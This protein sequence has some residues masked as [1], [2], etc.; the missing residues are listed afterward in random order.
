MARAMEPRAGR[1][2]GKTAY[3]AAIGIAIATALFLAWGNLALGVIGDEGNNANLMYGGV[4]AVG[5]IG[6]V[7][8]RFQPEGMA[9]ALIATAI[10]QVLVAVIALSAGWGSAPD[11]VM[12]TLFF[13]GL[14]LVAAWLFGRAARGRTAPVTA[15]TR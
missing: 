11:I 6:A 2:T 8:A 13:S 5:I 15:P 9:R 7:I 3:W 1:M 10:A 4:L 12:L 14:W